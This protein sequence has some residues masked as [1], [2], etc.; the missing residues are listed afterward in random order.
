MR[1]RTATGT[2]LLGL[3][4]LGCDRTSPS[5]TY[6]A[7]RQAFD[8]ATTVEEVKPFMDKATRAKVEAATP[9]DRKDGFEMMK[10]FSEVFEVAVGKETVTGEQAVVEATGVGA[11]EGKDTRAT[12]QMVREDGVW[13]VKH[14]KW[15]SAPEKTPAPP[16]S[17]AELLAD[18]KGERAAA[19][20]K[21]A[22]ALGDLSRAPCPDAAPALAATLR[23]PSE[24]IRG[25]AARALQNILRSARGSGHDHSALLPAI[26]EAK[27][28]AA[29]AEDVMLEIS[30]Q[31][32]LA[33]LGAPGISHLVKDLHSPDRSIRW[34]AAAGLGMMG[35]AAHEAVPALQAAA[36]EEK[37]QTVVSRIAD[38][39]KEISGP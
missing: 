25:N 5:Q 10:A 9:E 32:A 17:C 4:L 24:G 36:R 11:I 14:E 2:V 6:L 34:G 1:A 28:S 39:V 7:Y 3:G 29:A 27:K 23:D 22:A 19:R 16:R 15:D 13:K 21:A 20:A 12:V 31:N 26:V 33:A 35:K 8:K 18:L 37:D 38:A 30:L